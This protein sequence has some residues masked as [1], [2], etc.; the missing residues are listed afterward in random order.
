M[1]FVVKPNRIEVMQVGCHG[2]CSNNCFAK[3]NSLLCPIK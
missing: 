2:N 1:K 3:C